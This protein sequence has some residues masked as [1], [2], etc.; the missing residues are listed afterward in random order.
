MDIADLIL[1]VG[2]MP[3]RGAAHTG[4]Y[5]LLSEA[6]TFLESRALPVSDI[7][8]CGTS[9]QRFSPCCAGKLAYRSLKRAVLQGTRDRRFLAR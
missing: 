3:L 7:Q 8:V 4:S 2:L 5:S 9:I 6:L 1:D